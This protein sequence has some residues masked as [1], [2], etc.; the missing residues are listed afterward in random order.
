MKKRAM[1]PR[2]VIVSGEVTDLP[3]TLVTQMKTNDRMMSRR[4]QAKL[5]FFMLLHPFGIHYL[6]PA[7]SH[8]PGVDRW[9]NIGSTCWFC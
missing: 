2:V 3:E 4:M 1:E 6:V 8:Q 7:Y 5:L 9:V